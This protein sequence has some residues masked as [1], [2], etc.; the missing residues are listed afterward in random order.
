[1]SFQKFNISVPFAYKKI[2]PSYTTSWTLLIHELVKDATL[3][4]SPSLDFYGKTSLIGHLHTPLAYSS[5]GFRPVSK[6]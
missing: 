5:P 2:V 1:M 3:K 4:S 6:E